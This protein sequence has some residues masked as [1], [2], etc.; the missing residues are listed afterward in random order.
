MKRVI[1][2]GINVLFLYFESIERV[3]LMF[4]SD[5]RKAGAA[6]GRQ[7]L[8]ATGCEQRTTTSREQQRNATQAARQ[9]ST[10]KVA[11]Q[12]LATQATRRPRTTQ[13]ARLFLTLALAFSM[14]LLPGLYG[15][16]NNSQGNSGSGATSDNGGNSFGDADGSVRIASLKGPTSMG[17]VSLMDGIEQG[18]ITPEHGTYNFNIYGTP[19][20]IIPKLISGEVDIAL[21]PANL[22][23]VFYNKNGN[24]I[25]VLSVANLGVL[26]VV[27]ADESIQSLSD[28]AGR[29][30]LMTGL[31]TTPEYVMNHLL[32]AN[33]LSDQVT[34]EYKTEATELAAAVV[35]DPTAVAVLPEPYVSVVVDKNPALGVRISLTDEWNAISGNRQMITGITV[36]RDAFY[37]ENHAAV[38]EFGKLQKASV[39]A[40]NNDHAA[41][42]QLVVKYGILDDAAIAEAAI[43]RC[44]LVCMNNTEMQQAVG[45]YLQV[46]YEADPESVGGAVPG[47]SF[48]LYIE[49]KPLM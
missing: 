28:L 20:E 15:C 6:E 9:L 24:S 45:N 41:A 23:S 21:L 36:V 47:L 19:D 17:L 8:S 40:V 18:T 48:Y 44:N 14:L 16:T 38:I 49:E 13:A 22:A 33:G 27:S 4:A 37:D 12:P 5:N 42:A 30:V 10:A 46:L 35:A 31:G 34:L 32:S 26:Y 25:K 2:A 43:P 29:T 11:R 39:Q 3:R 7:Q 1:V